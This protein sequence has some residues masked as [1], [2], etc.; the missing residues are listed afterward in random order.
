[1][2][3]NEINK[4]TGRSDFKTQWQRRQQW[5]EPARKLV[6]D[7]ETFLRWAEKARQASAEPDVNVIPFPTHR[8][9]RWIPYAAAATLVIGVASIGLIRHNEIDTTLPI[10]KEVNVNGQTIRFVCNNDCSAQDVIF[11]V[12]DVIK[13]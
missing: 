9:N 10:A 4:S 11:A 5:Q 3:N 2:K 12:N 13:K 8:R 1:M 7:D 6:S